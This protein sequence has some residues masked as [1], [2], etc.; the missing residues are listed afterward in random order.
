M[1]SFYGNIKN[2][3]RASFIFDKIYPS[4]NAMDD[5][6]N[7]QDENG[8]YLGD[9][10]FVNRYILIDYNFDINTKTF[11]NRYDKDTL[12]ENNIYKAN[13]EIDADR[14]GA[15]YDSTVWMK[16]Y[17]DNQERYIMIAELNAASPTFEL[18]PDAP[19]EQNGEP[20]FDLRYSDELN[21]KYHVPKN[22]DFILNQYSPTANYSTTA[23]EN[24]YYEQDLENKSF[25]NTVDYPYFN[26]K[27]FSS[28][29][30]TYVST[31]AEGIYFNDTKSAVLY[32]EDEFIEIELT[33]DTYQKNK[34]YI[35]ST[36]GIF[37]KA[38]NDY[39]INATY[40][41]PSQKWENGEPKN[42]HKNDTK[43]LD[44]YLP[45]IGNAVSDLYDS[46]FGNPGDEGGERPFTK[47]QLYNFLDIEPYNNILPNDPISMTWAM[48][49]LKKYISELRYLS[50]G[51]NIIGYTNSINEY[52]LSNEYVPEAVKINNNYYLLTSEQLN[53]LQ[54]YNEDT[55][56]II[57][58]YRNNKSIGL[59]SDWTLNNEHAFG[60]IYNKPKVIDS[61]SI[62]LIWNSNTPSIN[63]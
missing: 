46:L 22:W 26:K 59:Q 35:Q 8:T 10:I 9:G 34:Y 31:T 63:E 48:E 32:P 40:Y 41:M 12:I 24:F 43:R 57:P 47:E 14:Y 38:L 54:D 6:L 50:H 3:S 11:V 29:T 4:R 28:I 42:I 36:S 23:N 53:A 25:N 60:Y 39:E 51:D 21:Y 7:A 5:A 62:V 30:K 15:N 55:G 20:H 2:N 19:S 45:S 1:A 44:I 16:I 18:L 33:K 52:E 58:V 37:E 27:G 56:Y 61:N 13:R 17:A 49:I